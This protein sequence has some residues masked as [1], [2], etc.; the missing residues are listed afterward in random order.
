MNRYNIFNQVHKGLRSLLYETALTIQQTDFMQKEEARLAL[1]KVTLVVELFEKHAHTE[2][3]FLLPALAE[4]EP[5][6]VT[7]FEEE[8]V[9][10]HELSNRL[11]DLVFVFTHSITDETRIMTGKALSVSFVEFLVF[12]LNHMAKEESVI[13]KLLWRY[14][15]D[16]QLQGI[17]RTIVSHIPPEHFAKFSRYMLRGLNNEEI[18][19]WFRQVKLTAPPFVYS[20]LT[21]TAEAELPAVRWMAILSRINGEKVMVA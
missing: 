14:Y 21:G 15:T 9:K 12:N 17:T 2:D 11:L 8:H 19:T 13:N 3:N 16:E 7:I 6:V 18:S 1:E 20:S 5:G 4:Y 10:D